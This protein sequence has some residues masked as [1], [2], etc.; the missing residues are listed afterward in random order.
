MFSDTD[1]LNDFIADIIFFIVKFQ[2]RSGCGGE[3]IGDPLRIGNH[4]ACLTLP[5]GTEIHGVPDPDGIMGFLVFILKGGKDYLM[6]V[7]VLGHI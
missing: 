1:G 3:I 5:G 4:G 2:H 7:V 6:G